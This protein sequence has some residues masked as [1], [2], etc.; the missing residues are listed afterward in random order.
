MANIPDRFTQDAEDSR[1]R[2][3]KLM[4]NNATQLIFKGT[5]LKNCANR[6]IKCD[7]CF[8]FSELIEIK[9]K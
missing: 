5:C 7:D 3:R 2:D 4:A 1:A 8:R 6:D 9:S